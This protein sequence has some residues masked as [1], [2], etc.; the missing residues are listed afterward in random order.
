MV[1]DT[2]SEN[3]EAISRELVQ[4]A[5]DTAIADCEKDTKQIVLDTDSENIEAISR[6]LVQSAIDTAIADCEMDTKQRYC[7]II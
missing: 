7:V 1:L 2:D 5:I 4:S 6:E 3:I